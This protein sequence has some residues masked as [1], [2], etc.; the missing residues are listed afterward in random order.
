MERMRPADRRPRR[1]DELDH[2][3][4]REPDHAASRHEVLCQFCAAQDLQQ[5]GHGRGHERRVVDVE[6]EVVVV[7]VMVCMSGE[8]LGMEEGTHVES[9]VEHDRLVRAARPRFAGLF[10]IPSDP[11]RW[12]HDTKMK[13]THR[14]GVH[15]RV[16]VGL[17]QRLD[18]G[19]LRRRRLRVRCAHVAQDRG[20]DVVC[21]PVEL[22]LLGPVRSGA[23]P[24][25]A[26][27][28]VRIELYNI[29]YALVLH[30]TC[31]VES[32]SNSR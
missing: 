14:P 24:V 28:L 12:F 29:T 10:A 2:L 31:A 30:R 11:A 6:P 32:G 7:L 19:S 1:D 16:Q 5:H 4:L 26:H 22:G 8:R 9:E 27:W 21:K 23:N 15:E 20:V 13:E 25:V 18:T 3:V 17:L